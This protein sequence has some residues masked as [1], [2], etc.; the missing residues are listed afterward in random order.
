MSDRPADRAALRA[1]IEGLKNPGE[2]PVADYRDTFESGA[3]IGY[4][5]ALADVLALLDAETG[6]VQTD[7]PKGAGNEP[8]LLLNAYGRKCWDAGYNTAKAEGIA[9]AQEK[10]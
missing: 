1:Q 4:Y 8:R 5:K 9:P 10:R 6:T 3:A 2:D 7:E